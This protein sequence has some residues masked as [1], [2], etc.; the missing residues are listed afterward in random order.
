MQ[1]CIH[2]F[3]K[4][5]YADPFSFFPMYFNILQEKSAIL[6][7][8]VRLFAFM[9][10]AKEMFI[11]KAFNTS[12]T[13]KKRSTTFSPSACISLHHADHRYRTKF[14]SLV[15]L[16]CRLVLFFSSSSVFNVCYHHVK[17]VRMSARYVFDQRSAVSAAAARVHCTTPALRKK[18]DKQQREEEK[19]VSYY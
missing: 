13:K 8:M 3:V 1:V 9:P 16:L 7:H 11:C 19:D 4:C 2:L 12:P 5:S 15:L 14:L 6:A 17:K 18:T 10:K